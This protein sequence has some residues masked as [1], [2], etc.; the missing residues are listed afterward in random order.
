MMKPPE[1]KIK[2]LI[3]SA[4]VRRDELRKALAK[5]DDTMDKMVNQAGL[6]LTDFMELEKQHDAATKEIVELVR[7]MVED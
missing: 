4:K 5:H 3:D 1:K 2:I 6:S 7:S